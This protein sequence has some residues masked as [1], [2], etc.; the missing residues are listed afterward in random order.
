MSVP[1]YLDVNA[2]ETTASHARFVIAGIDWVEKPSN[3]LLVPIYNILAK[4]SNLVLNVQ[5]DGRVV[6]Y[7]WL[8]AVSIYTPTTMAIVGA[9]LAGNF[10]AGLTPE[11]HT[12]FYTAPREL[13]PPKVSWKE[14]E[15]AIESTKHFPVSRITQDHH[16]YITRRELAAGFKVIG[17]VHTYEATTRKQAFLTILKDAY[18]LDIANRVSIITHGMYILVAPIFAVKHLIKIVAISGGPDAYMRLL[19]AESGAAKQ[20][21]TLFRDDL[22]AVFELQVLRNRVYDEVDW[23]KEIENRQKPKVVPIASQRVYEISKDIFLEARRGGARQRRE[24]WGDY[25]AARWSH[26]PVGSVVSQYADDMKLKRSLPTDAKVKA[27]WFAASDKSDYEHWASRK[28]EIYA[29]TST[30]YEWGKVRALYGCD[31]TS[32]LHADYSM[33]DCEDTLPP[34]FPVGKRANE[35]YVRD[36]IRKFSDGVPF[37]YDFDDFNAQHSTASM[38]AVLKAWMAVFSMTLTDEQKRS[39]EWTVRS[40]SDQ[41]VRFN[42]IGETHGINGTL[43]SG[44]RLTSFIN[45]VLNRVYLVEAGIADKSIYA[46]HNGDDV[47]ATTPTVAD[48]VEVAEKAEALGVRAQM[49]KMNIGTIG[50]FLRVDAR[51]KKSTSAQYLARAVATATHGRVEIAPANDLREL[52][53]S[54][55]ER[56]DA[57]IRRGGAINTTH[58]VRERALRFIEDLF[59]VKPVIVR[60]LRDLHPL[61]GGMNEDADVG[62]L[63]VN[64]RMMDEHE[65]SFDSFAAIRRGINDYA[66]HVVRQLGL[67]YNEADRETMFKSAVRGLVRKKIRYEIVVDSDPFMHVYRGVFK[68]WRKHSFVTAIAKARSL[69]FVTATELRTIDSVLAHLIRTAPNPL[70]FMKAAV[71]GA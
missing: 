30:K 18:K 28:P 42:D 68:A 6:T 34:Y 70:M 50:E 64:R 46:L 22:A 71:G 65:V 59:E 62:C 56:F 52:V 16:M 45:S 57:I 53:R 9:A 23:Y 2:K 27:A 69:G 21:Q 40:V 26:M 5:V 12:D 43:L 51:A 19:K 13:M 4:E 38:Q 67:R 10:R 63:R 1:A 41:F 36:I 8:K 60:M 49:A 55:Y 3:G 33:M 31:V 14:L 20:L 7:Y 11:N 48:A 17:N 54:T 44:W 24:Y 61:Q 47:Y 32:F 25:W 58:A 39:M 37:C 66:N 15:M 35:A 29:S